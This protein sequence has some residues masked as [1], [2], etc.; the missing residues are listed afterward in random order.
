M[1]PAA[2]M[3]DAVGSV[4]SRDFWR[5]PATFWFGAPSLP[6]KFIVYFVFIVMFYLEQPKAQHF[7]LSKN[8]FKSAAKQ[9]TINFFST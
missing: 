9:S 1:I 7:T 6:S 3:L 8:F 2:P 4:S 5:L